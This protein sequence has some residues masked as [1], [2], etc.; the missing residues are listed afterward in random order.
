MNVR[1]PNQI[2]FYKLFNCNSD[3]FRIKFNGNVNQDIIKGKLSFY[4]LNTIDSSVI[5]SKDFNFEFNDE[6][7]DNILN[8]LFSYIK[9]KIKSEKYYTRIQKYIKDNLLNRN[10]K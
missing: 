7:I 5:E 4:I 10:K 1:K 3:R 6:S 8:N 2:K 9:R